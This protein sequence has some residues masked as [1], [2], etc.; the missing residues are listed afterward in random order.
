MNVKDI[1]RLI[2]EK[3]YNEF[4]AALQKISPR[5]I[6]Y[7]EGIDGAFQDEL[8]ANVSAEQFQKWRYFLSI[9]AENEYVMK[10]NNNLYKLSEEEKRQACLI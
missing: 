6:S 9:D 4:C 8:E 1:S 5:V 10:H 3:K 2:K 7:I